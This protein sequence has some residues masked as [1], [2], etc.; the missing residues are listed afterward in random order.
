MSSNNLNNQ[1]PKINSFP[2]TKELIKQ[3]K[4]LEEKLKNTKISHIPIWK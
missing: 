2:L 1:L 3:N 4:Y